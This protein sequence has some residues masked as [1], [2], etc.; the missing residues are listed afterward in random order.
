MGPSIRAELELGIKE[1]PA[2]TR[3]YNALI[4]EEM[5]RWSDERKSLGEEKAKLG[6][7]GNALKA[8]KAKVCKTRARNE[9]FLDG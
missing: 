2:E 3:K 9:I 6:D 4:R 8:W 7:S 5:E 1:L